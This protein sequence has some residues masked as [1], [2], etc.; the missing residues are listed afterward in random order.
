[1]KRLFFLTVFSGFAY[2]LYSGVHYWM[3]N[4]DIFF[5]SSIEVSGT[6]ILTTDEIREMIDMEP[7]QRILEVEIAPIKEKLLENPFIK[8]VSIGRRFPSTIKVNVTERNPVAYVVAGKVS[9]VGEEGFILPK[10]IN[11]DNPVDYPVISGV[12]LNKSE[13]DEKSKSLTASLD[14]LR[15]LETRLPDIVGQ[16]SEIHYRRD[17]GFSIFLSGT[18]LRIDCGRDELGMKLDRLEYFLTFHQRNNPDEMLQYINLEYKE[19]IVV[20]ES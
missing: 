20:K 8:D 9:M 7:G 13:K 15:L 14:F 5:V 11:K 16:I 18:G 4:S 19:L 6:G 12:K 17:G 10:R 3:S 1:M 2:F